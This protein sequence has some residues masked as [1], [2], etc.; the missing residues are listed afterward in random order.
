MKLLHTEACRAKEPTITTT[1]AI[2]VRA[3]VKV[4]FQ[5]LAKGFKRSHCNP[6]V[7]VTVD[8]GNLDK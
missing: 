8:I 2:M 6:E 4:K 5:Q 1:M 3:V 7:E